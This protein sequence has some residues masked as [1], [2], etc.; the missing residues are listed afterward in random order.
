MLQLVAGLTVVFVGYVLYE[1]FK[2][3]SAETS[4]QASAKAPPPVAAKPQEAAKA[5][6]VTEAK[7][8]APEPVTAAPAAEARKAAPEP[9]EAAPAAVAVKPEPEAKKA[10]AEESRGGLLIKDPAS[11]EA[12]P[13]PTNY[14]FAKKWVKE[15]M[16]AEGLL[17]KVYKAAELDEA[18]TRKV[19]EALEK[20]RAMKKYHA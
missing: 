16:V 4:R 15:A 5:A 13:A 10:A 1:V 20:F 17:D 14:R 19:R 8:S 12:G 9:A 2:T 3:V 6:A 18:G 11:G 7:K